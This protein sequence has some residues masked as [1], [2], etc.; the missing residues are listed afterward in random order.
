MKI[1][2]IYAHT[3]ETQDFFGPPE[4]LKTDF[5]IHFSQ[6]LPKWMN[7]KERSLNDIL[8]ALA[9]QEAF[10]IQVL[11]KDPNSAPENG[12]EVPQVDEIAVRMLGHGQKSDELFAAAKFL[13]G[14]TA[15]TV[16]VRVALW[17]SDGDAVAAALAAYGLSSDSS[18]RQA[19]QSVCD[20][21]RNTAEPLQKA[22]TYDFRTH[23][24]A[25]SA[26][27]EMAERVR[28]AIAAG[29]LKAANLGG[30]HSGGALI[31]SDPQGGA[32]LLKPG[33]GPQSPAAGARQDRSSQSER[34]S[35]FWLISSLCGLGSSL[36]ECHLLF[37]DGREYASMELLPHDYR[38][39]EDLLEEKRDLVRFSMEESRQSGLLHKWAVLDFVLGNPDR[40]AGNIMLSPKGEV[41]LIDHGSAFAGS[42]F[43]PGYD[44]ASFV[45]F[46][47]RY[48]VPASTN[49]NKLPPE[50]KIRQMPR[51]P[52]AVEPTLAQWVDSINAD[53]LGKTLRDS[54]IDP[55]ASLERLVR[56]KSIP[57][58][59]MSLGIN[60]LWIGA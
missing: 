24:T 3:G 16:P 26:G 10:H 11:D 35:A 7:W 32:L 20:A 18:A 51:M 47:L 58:D 6:F 50:D 25:D 21:R 29:S 43:N 36:P 41:K 4:E 19:L 28:R 5:L 22:T 15:P 12:D 2:L 13:S 31:A 1:R 53:H 30:R 8:S 38:P 55:M 59:Q 56:V 17:E 52:Q 42:A 27:Q 54:H 45:P 23:V 46:Y 44:R 60:R 9:R 14:G 33:S 57:R 49:F 39:A 37:V 48:L 34:E 40:H